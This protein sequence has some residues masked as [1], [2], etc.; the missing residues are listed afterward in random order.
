MAA[1]GR[2]VRGGVAVEPVVS[3]LRSG[4]GGRV[5]SVRVAGVQRARIL[6]AAMEI[7]CELGYGAMSTARVSA[8]AGVSRRTFYELFEDREDCLL[9]VFDE[10]VARATVVAQRAASGRE[11][12][13][14]R[15]R[16]GLFALLVFLDDE[17][18]L[19]S[20]L[21][22]GVLGA[23]PRVLERRA[24]I[25][26]SLA[27]VVDGGRSE[28]PAGG[29]PLPPL[30]G[31]GVVGA[32]LSVIHGRMLE[33]RGA[34]LM[35]LLNPLMGMIV[36][37]YLG[38]AAARKELGRSVPRVR[39]TARRGSRSFVGQ[40]PLKGLEVR[41]TYRTLRVVY[42]ISE[43]GEGGSSPNNR[44]VAEHAGVMDQGQISKLLARLE[45]FGLV[46]NIGVGHAKGEPNAWVLTAK[47]RELAQ[48]ISTHDRREAA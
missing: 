16:A 33:D 32:V 31:E 42:A 38:Q 37:P 11:G 7:A 9:A 44:E 4:G 18:G 34:P 14:E 26:E 48:S 19:G 23:G 27:A 15:V 8:R 12:W 20:L 13:C 3:R 24:R 2:R 10:A 29:G 21:V 22:V 41:P 28:A 39:R 1:A 5:S 25:I 36:L 47:G 43:L 45:H 17:P 46:Q 30:T 6:A 35:G 40:H